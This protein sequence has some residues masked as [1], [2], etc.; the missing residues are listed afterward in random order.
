MDG[1]MAERN[2]RMEGCMDEFINGPM[3]GWGEWIV[4]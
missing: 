1:W 2:V 3:N 4:G